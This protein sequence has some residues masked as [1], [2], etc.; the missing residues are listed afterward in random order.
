[1]TTS[2]KIIC[3][4]CGEANSEDTVSCFNC[5]AATSNSL[6][7]SI[8]EISDVIVAAEETF[9]QNKNVIKTTGF[10]F[11]NLGLLIDRTASSTEFKE[12]INTFLKCLLEELNKINSFPC[13]TI[14]THGD[15]DYGEFEE[16]LVSDSSDFKEI[17]NI[18][19]TIDFSGGGDLPETHLHALDYYVKNNIN[20]KL[21]GKN[22]IV[23]LATGETK[24]IDEINELVEKLHNSNSIV[25]FVCEQTPKMYQF[26][27]QLKQGF[28]IKISN[29]PSEI[30]IKKIAKLIAGTMNAVRSKTI[31][32]PV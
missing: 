23:L 26:I 6:T 19:S 27:T 14:Q 7:S 2:E 16:T 30:S 11:T 13:I 8:D 4:V 29:D 9:L 15:H 21:T 1:M 25:F 10:S 18:V 3:N 22:V 31:A 32:M 28:L 24:D 12:G 5:G 17:L 20:A